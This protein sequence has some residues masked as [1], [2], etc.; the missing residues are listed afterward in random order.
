MKS[1]VYLSV[2]TAC[3]PRCRSLLVYI[4]IY[5]ERERDIHL[6]SYDLKIE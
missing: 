6:C 2:V 5:R 1:P 3:L 4:Y